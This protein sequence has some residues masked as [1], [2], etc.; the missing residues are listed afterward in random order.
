[1][2]VRDFNMFVQLLKESPAARWREGC[3]QNS[4]IRLSGIQVS[5]HISTRMGETSS[6]TPTTAF[7][8]LSQACNQP[9]T[10][11]KLWIT[12]SRHEVWATMS[13]SWIQRG[14]NHSRKGLTKGSSSS[15][16]VPP[17][18]E[19]IPPPALPFFRASF[20]NTFKQI[21]RNAQFMHSFSQRPEVRSIQTHEC[22]ESGLQKKS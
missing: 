17:T 22:Y 14:F 16:D 19:N 6:V 1:M 12:G 2:H 3:A 7:F 18:D 20:S 15:T 9:K 13:Y 21:R 10:R 8:W 5:H 11:P 4:V